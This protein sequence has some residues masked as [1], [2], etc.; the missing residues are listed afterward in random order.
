ME[1]ILASI[2]RII[3]EEAQAPA[4]QAEEVM[5][6]TNDM[7]V[8]AAPSAAP[9]KPLETIDD[10]MESCQPAARPGQPP[11]GAARKRGAAAHLRARL[12]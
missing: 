12:R 11:P 2:R 6:L 8:D 7:R 4:A 5:E 9:A 3:S 10:L 1:E